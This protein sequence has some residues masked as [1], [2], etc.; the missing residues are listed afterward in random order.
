MEKR[1]IKC[2]HCSHELSPDFVKRSAGKIVGWV[3]GKAKAH[4][5]E[6]AR[7]NVMARWAKVRAAKK[8]SLDH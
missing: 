4:S 7:A 6:V 1:V 3:K 8:T 2:P 5:S